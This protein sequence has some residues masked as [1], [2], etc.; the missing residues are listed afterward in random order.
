[1]DPYSIVFLATTRSS[2]VGPHVFL[3]HYNPRYKPLDQDRRYK[4]LLR[5]HV[6]PRV[7]AMLLENQPHSAECQ[8]DAGSSTPIS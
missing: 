8:L 6:K 7:I 3:L 5:T 1:M 2:Y 4:W